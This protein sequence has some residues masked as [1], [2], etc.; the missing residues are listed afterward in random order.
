MTTEF[1][2]DAVVVGG[3]PAGATAAQ[4]LAQRGKQVLLLDK[5]GRIKPCGGAIPPRLI[6]DFQ[7]P[8]ELLVAKAKSARMVSPLGKT[9]DI[10]IE[11]GF[12]GMVDRAQFDELLRQRAVSVGATREDGLFES[13][14]REGPNVRIYYRTRGPKDGDQG[15]VKSVLAK[16]VVGADGAKSQVGRSAGVKGCAEANYVFAYH[17]IIK[18][19]LDKPLSFDA[20]RCDV[21]YQKPISPDFYGWVFPHGDTISVGTG[22]ADKGFSLRNAVA[23]LREDIGLEGAELIRHEGAPL[24]MKPLKKWDDGQQVVLAGDAAGVVAPASGEGIYYAMLG[25]QLA[26]EAVAEFVETK[27]PAKLKLARKRFMKEHRMT[28]LVLGI[29]QYFW[30]STDKRR[31]SFVKMCEDKDVQ[32]LTFESYMNKKLVRKKPMAH[33]KIFIKD[34][35]HLL[36]LA[37]V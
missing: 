18:T 29:M 11:N 22:S 15:A 17:E 32:K 10:P 33:L 9:V 7:I 14:Q 6:K 24:P 26:G 19:P 28:F 16:A 2:Y 1:I 25:G 5:R 13:L 34:M 37:K 23:K 21:L 30:Y 27:D 8:D 12:V 36:G 31:E 4:T 35:G 3:G 20:T